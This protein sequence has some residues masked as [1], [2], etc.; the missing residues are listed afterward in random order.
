MLIDWFTVISQ[1]I[2]FLILVW[3]LKRFLYKPI[4]NAIDAR[5]ARIADTV[6]TAEQQK[7]A[8]ETER[9]RLTKKN[10]DFDR[11]RAELISQARDDAKAMGEKFVEKE[12]LNADAVREKWQNALANDQQRFNAEIVHC[13]Q[14]EAFAI[15]RQT[16]ADLADTTLE[17]RMV[18][19]FVRRLRSTKIP[20]EN[21][22]DKDCPP[23]PSVVVKSAFD[24]SAA[25]QATLRQALSE[26]FATEVDV[27]F[28]T[29][30][31]LLG[32]IELIANDKKLAWSIDDYLSRLN[33]SVSGVLNNPSSS[34]AAVKTGIETPSV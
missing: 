30:T 7:E 18:E 16:L 2:N 14:D 9:A 20:V 22:Q 6:K 1:V 8:A 34:R 27:K 3:L 32:G 13:V 26:T 25:Q 21:R 33:D 28:V 4:L 10:E 19:T 24:L 15:A 5:E 23:P 11:Q 17:E 12:R 31:N 29:E